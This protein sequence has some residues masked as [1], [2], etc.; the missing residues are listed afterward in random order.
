VEVSKDIAVWPNDE[1]G[2][3]AL[4]R[5][6]SIQIAPLIVFVRRPLEEQIIERRT[7]AAVVFF[8]SLNN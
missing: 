3:F 8:W 6:G 7:L 1:T 2:A 4:D 5:P